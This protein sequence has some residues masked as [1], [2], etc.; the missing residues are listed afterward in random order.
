RIAGEETQ[1]FADGHLQ[2]VMD[3]LALVVNLE[4]AGFVAGAVTFF[5]GQ[6]NVGEE[7][8]FDGDRA[9][10]F[11]D[12]AAAAGDVEGEV[13]SGVAA[14]LGLG[15]RGEEL[16]D[17]VEGPDVG[18]RVGARGAA[19]GRLIDEDDVVEALDPFDV[20]IDAGGIAA[21]GAAEVMGD[22]FVDDLVNQG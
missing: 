13:S 3:A 6:F 14:A 7:L 22:G 4:G 15:L 16:A 11:A 20:L 8:H 10:A 5:A 9:V 18:D 21:L 19:D 1:S 17:G 12:I 2:D